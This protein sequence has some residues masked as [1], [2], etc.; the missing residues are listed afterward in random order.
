[1]Q[2][3]PRPLVTPM[4]LPPCPICGAGYLDDPEGREAHVVVF[5]HEPRERTTW[6][7]LTGRNR[8][9]TR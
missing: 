7:R 4:L 8:D 6:E 2:A 3:P 5:G 1:M 9:A